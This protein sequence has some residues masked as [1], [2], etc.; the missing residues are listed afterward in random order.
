MTDDQGIPG[1]EPAEVDAPAGSEAQWEG[2]LAPGTTLWAFVLGHP[3]LAQEALL[4]AM[5]LQARGHLDLDDAA[6]VHRTE[7]GRVRIVQTRD[8]STGQGAI[9][10]SWWGLLAGLFIPGG[11]LLG[12]AL[13]AAVGG[14]FAKMRDIG[15]DDAQM[16]QM[17]EQLSEG[18]SALFLLVTDCHRARTLHE[19]GRFEGRLLFT[20]ADDDLA[21]QV[22]DRLA[23]DPWGTTG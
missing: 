2:E 7:G 8:V 20:T 10:G 18:E 6:I 23:V 9:S 4:A 11:P 13:G 22:S 3:L 1:H 5:R 19:V 12:A 14:I 17:G 21:E 15:I 16:R